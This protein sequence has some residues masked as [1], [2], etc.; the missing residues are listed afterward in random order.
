MGHG[1]RNNSKNRGGWGRDRA[2]LVQ[3]IPKTEIAG[4]NQPK[5][6]KSELFS[7]E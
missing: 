5:V 7:S 1:E 6:L 2:K 4:I 3:K